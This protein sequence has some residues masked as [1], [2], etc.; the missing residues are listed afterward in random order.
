MITLATTN[1][2]ISFREGEESKLWFRVKKLFPQNAQDKEIVIECLK[3][4][5]AHKNKEKAG[6]SN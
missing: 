2:S 6:D 3:D 4:Y 1:I 5:I